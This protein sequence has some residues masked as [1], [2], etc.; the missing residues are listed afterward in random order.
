MVDCHSSPGD[1]VIADGVEPG[2]AAF[3]AAD[4]HGGAI[5]SDGVEGSGGHA[6]PDEDQALDLE[7]EQLFHLALFNHWIVIP[8]DEHRVIT[9]LPDLA[10]NPVDDL[11]V[12]WIEEVEYDH[13]EGVT[14][15][16]CQASGSGIGPIAELGGSLDNRRPALR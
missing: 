3:R 13:P 9:V 14:T 12:D 10:L 7:F 16:V 6:V 4:H 11:G 2:D 5:A 15:P 1:V 8:G